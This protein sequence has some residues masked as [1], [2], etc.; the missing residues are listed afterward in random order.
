MDA[1]CGKQPLGAVGRP[2]G[3]AVAGGDAV[4]DQRAAD[5]EGA[6][7]QISVI[8]DDV[9]VLDKDTSGMALC[10]LEDES[11]QGAGEGRDEL[12]GHVGSGKRLQAQ[13][14]MTNWPLS[15]RSSMPLT[16][17]EA[18]SARKRM[19]AATS[20]GRQARFIGSPSMVMR[21]GSRPLG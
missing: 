18:S 1:Q 15:T 4:R 19:A 8:D 5:F 16:A 9:A 3:D 7:R 17:R 14:L 13:M 2:D 21:A 20:V 10:G 12:F 11:G 6:R